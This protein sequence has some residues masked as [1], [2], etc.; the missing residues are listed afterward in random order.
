MRIITKTVWILSVVS[1]LA[2]IASEML[3]P[4]IPIYLEQVGFTVIW[5]GLLEGFANF[6]AGIS[7]GY[8]GKLSDE[9]GVRL[10][11]VKLGYL[12]SGIAK[13]MIAFFVQPVWILCMRSIDRLGKGIRTSARDAIL[14]HEAT[15]KTKARIFG[16]HRG[17]DTLGATMGPVIALVFLYFYPASYRTIFF[18]AFIPGILSFLLIFLLKETKRPVSTLEKGNFF[19]FLKYWKIAGTEFKKVTTGLLLIAL[20]NSSD[21]FL[22]LKTK[23]IT[24]SDTLTITAYIFYNF[25]YAALSFPL[26]VLG[27]RLGVKKIFLPGLFLLAIVYSGFAIATSTLTLFILFFLYGVYAAATDGIV[28]AWITNLAHEKNTATAIG[29]YTSLESVCTLSASVIAGALWAGF[30]SFYAF[31]ATALISFLV[32]LYFLLVLRQR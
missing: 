24:G 13:P 7:K 28:K 5:I 6:T 18:L 11:F 22:L 15:P 21:F 27:D 8:F 17:M 4:V 31:G 3:Y 10:P 30:G 25:I 16:F 2:D 9:K 20:F 12:L 14:S 23:E 1:L 19:S 29:F 26:G 32:V